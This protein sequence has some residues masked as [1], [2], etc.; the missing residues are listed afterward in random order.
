MSRNWQQLSFSYTFDH[1][2]DEVTCSYTVPYTYTEVQHHMTKISNH[3]PIT[4]IGKSLGN[5]NIPIVRISN[6]KNLPVIIV[7]GR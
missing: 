4:N 1:P 2:D 3:L 6:A 5:L 7:I